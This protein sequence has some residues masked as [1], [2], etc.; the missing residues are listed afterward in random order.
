MRMA[1]TRF[2]YCDLTWLKIPPEDGSDIGLIFS[3]TYDCK[4]GLFTFLVGVHLY[5]PSLGAGFQFAWYNLFGN[6]H[7]S[8]RFFM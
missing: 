4:N 6:L 7:Q 5:F 8:L 2:S 3:V 1:L